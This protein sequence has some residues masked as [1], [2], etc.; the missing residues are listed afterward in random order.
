MCVCVC[1][2]KKV[3][4]EFPTSAGR[5]VMMESSSSALSFVFIRPTDREMKRERVSAIED[6]E[7]KQGIYAFGLQRC[8]VDYREGKKKRR[9][10][11]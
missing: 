7:Q 4:A 6:G 9:K 3:G 10:E 2:A 11:G 8:N 1:E 5:Q